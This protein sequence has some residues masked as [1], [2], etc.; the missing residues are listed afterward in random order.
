MKIRN[1]FTAA[2]LAVVIAAGSARAAEPAAPATLFEYPSVPDKL[3]K[4]A[5]RANFMV[6]HLWDKCDLEK[7]AVTDLAAFHN[8]FTDYL[9]FFALADKAVVEK[10]IKKYV[11]R[12][13]KNPTNLNL[14]VGM[15]HSDV[16][17]LRSQYCS[18]EVYTM[19]ADNIAA[20]KKV[21]KALKAKL[22][23]QAAVL[24]NSAVGATVADFPLRQSPAGAASLYGLTAG[25]ESP[26]VGIV[27][28]VVA[29]VLRVD[30]QDVDAHR[31]LVVF[32]Q[33]CHLKQHTHAAGTVVGTH[34][35]FA[36]VVGVGIA[37]GPRTTVPMSHQQHASF[38]FRI[39]LTHDVARVQQ[40]AVKSLQVG[41]LLSHRCAA[42]PQPRGNPVAALRM[43]IGV[44]HTLPKR[45]LARHK[46]IG[47][48]GV[49]RD[50]LCLIGCLL[51][52][53]SG[54]FART[55]CHRHNAASHQSDCIFA[56]VHICLKICRMQ[57]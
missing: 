10:S 36:A 40:S 44:W 52:G 8:T 46:R 3:T 51:R 48:V 18:D 41:A 54:S 31:R 35:R 4:P 20:A 14:T 55:S 15:L 9:S 13:A 2:A 25:T 49:E 43:G 12:V 24:A 1:I 47:A 50:F 19:F 34:H 23:A 29:P 27:A 38:L 28:I 11:E 6:E 5:M 7:T 42:L 53:V 45:T 26:R 21:D 33:T 17:N 39:K 22:Q 56:F 57:N 16:L 32:E 37:V 30:E